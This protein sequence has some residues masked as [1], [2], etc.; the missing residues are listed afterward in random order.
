MAERE[1][2]SQQELKTAHPLLMRYARVLAAHPA[3][4]VASS[5]LCAAVMAWVAIGWLSLD[6]NTDSLIRSD[7]PFMVDYRAFLKEFGDLEYVYVAV[8]GHGDSSAAR[9]AVDDLVPRL[10]AIESLEEI[11]ATVSAQEQW[12]M[13]P[14]AMSDREL[15]ALV[16][17]AAAFP[18]LGAGSAAPVAAEAEA[19]L[20]TLGEE[21]LALSAEQRRALGGGALLLVDT[22]TGQGD[23]AM[24]GAARQPE[25]LVSPSGRMLFVEILPRKEFAALETIEGSLAEIRRAIDETARLYGSVEIG[26]TGKPVLQADEL[27]TTNLD[28][29][30]GTVIAAVLIALLTMWLLRTAIPALLATLV[31]ALAFADTYGAAALL[32]GRLNLLSLVFMLV[33]VSAG[34]DYGIHFVARVTEFKERMDAETAVARAIATNTIP[35]WTGA[36]TSAIVFF[37]ALLTDFGGLEELGVIAG[38]GLILCALAMTTTLPAATLLVD[39]F[40]DR[41]GSRQAPGVAARRPIRW[42]GWVAAIRPG[43][44]LIACLGG[45]VLFAA[46]IPSL[47]YESNLLRLQAASLPSVAWEHRVLADSASTSWFAGVIARSE[48]EIGEIA[49]RASTEQTIESV[50]SVLDIVKEDTPERVALRKALADSLAIA[51]HGRATE[52]AAQQPLESQTFDRIASSLRSLVALGGFAASPEELAPLRKSAAGAEELASALRD[53]GRA[54]AA[55]SAAQSRVATARDALPAIGD[56][57]RSGLRESLPAALRARLV[58]PSGGLLVSLIPRDDLWEFDPLTE[59]VAAIRRV[60]PHATGVPITVYESLLDMRSAFL[61][62]STLSLVAIAVIVYLDFRSVLATLTCIV[63]LLVAMAWTLGA[64]SVLGISLNLANFFGIPMLLGFGIDSSVHLMHRARETGD[65]RSLGWTTRA[66]V[67]SAATT[68]IGFGTLL[69]AAHRG[70]Q[71]LGWLIVIGSVATIGSSVVLLPALLHRHPRLMGL[72]RLPTE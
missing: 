24:L 39:R 30:R 4:I 5:V 40:R 14:R 29:T 65:P 48:E 56:G 15:D 53:P 41:R 67:V 60:S 71:S 38:T 3:R 17:A 16:G 27:A 47:R 18:A 11:H 66:V 63:T 70:L 43:W 6:A 58:S 54:A 2:D 8:D 37:T 12:R 10:R 68:I 19:M 32:V 59:F 44:M 72:R 33:L 1:R 64:L 22:L 46:C 52:P 26:L 7:R 42:T 51:S 45:L 34:I 50:R 69:F 21:G 49:G 35:I 13:A 28:M 57:A 61:L 20:R 9:Q 55:M 23:A 36:L 62:M 31:L 25:Y